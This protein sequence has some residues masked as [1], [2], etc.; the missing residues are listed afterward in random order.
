MEKRE[1]ES[2]IDG[3]DL[4]SCLASPSFATQPPHQIRIERDNKPHFL[5]DFPSFMLSACPTILRWFSFPPPRH[6]G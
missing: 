5:C 1:R 2:E 4:T 6:T 3:V